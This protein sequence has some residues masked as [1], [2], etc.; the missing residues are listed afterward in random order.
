MRDV[1]AEETG[2]HTAVEYVRDAVE[3]VTSVFA[4]DNIL[5]ENMLFKGLRAMNQLPRVGAPA[6]FRHVVLIHLYSV[7]VLTSSSSWCKFLSVCPVSI[8]MDHLLLAAAPRGAICLSLSEMRCHRL[9]V[10]VEC[11]SDGVEAQKS[12]SRGEHAKA[13]LIMPERRQTQTTKTSSIYYKGY[14]EGT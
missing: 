14:I 5:P 2:G 12:G 6:F 13:Q 1:V 7:L 11:I 10:F 8:N 3:L 9:G 4:M